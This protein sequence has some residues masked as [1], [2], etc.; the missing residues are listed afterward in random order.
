MPNM[1]M[2]E[3]VPSAKEEVQSGKVHIHSRRTENQDFVSCGSDRVLRADQ[4]TS[5]GENTIFHIIK[6][7]EKDSYAILPQ[8]CVNTSG[9]LFVTAGGDE[10]LKADRIWI[11]KGETFEIKKDKNNIH[12]IKSKL[13]NRY[14]TTTD[15]GTLVAKAKEAK[16]WEQFDFSS[17]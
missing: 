16:Q 12:T 1:S 9:I 6:L 5:V 4:H 15:D 2:S 7:S 10:P 3:S 11:L 8:A 17:A 14:V 13:N